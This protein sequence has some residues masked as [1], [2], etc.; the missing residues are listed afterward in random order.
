[1][2]SVHQSPHDVSLMVR[3]YVHS[4]ELCQP[5]FIAVPADHLQLLVAGQPQSFVPR[6]TYSMEQRAP[7]LKSAS[8]LEQFPYR[9][10][11]G[12]AYLEGLAYGTAESWQTHPGTP[13]VDLRARVQQGPSPEQ[14][15]TLWSPPQNAIEPE[16]SP[17]VIRARERGQETRARPARLGRGRFRP[18][19]REAEP[20]PLFPGDF[21]R[22]TP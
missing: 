10:R 14:A 5:V 16:L 18:Q 7:L 17:R 20:P 19:K 1:M 21:R 3:K 13:T 22:C 15:L 11:E 4:S 12:A 8:M 6:L 9:L 2:H